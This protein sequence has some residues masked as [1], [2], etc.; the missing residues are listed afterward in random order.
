M[1][2]N[3]TID[4]L[5]PAHLETKLS[6]MEESIKLLGA[7]LVQFSEA[8]TNVLAGTQ[9][10]SQPAEAAKPAAPVAKRG[11]TRRTQAEAITNRVARAAEKTADSKELHPYAQ[12]AL[13]I[14]T[15]EK[16]IR[17]T[18]LADRMGIKRSLA[19]H[20]MGKL[21]SVGK[22][23]DIVRWVK[24]ADGGLRKNHVFYR[25]DQVVTRDA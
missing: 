19:Y 25:P 23:V 3:N 9:G 1:E 14:L 16:R 20:H 11:R 8:V 12:Q 5:V 15:A 22:A 2:N 10:N 7:K 6:T 21:V 13:E 4:S 17:G 24:G 18:D